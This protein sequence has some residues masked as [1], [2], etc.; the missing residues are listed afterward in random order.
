MGQHKPLSEVIDARRRVI[1]TAA[2]EEAI[3]EWPASKLRRVQ[4]THSAIVLASEEG[5]FLS[6]ATPMPRS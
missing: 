6:R 4:S 5:L 3:H 1:K 2:L